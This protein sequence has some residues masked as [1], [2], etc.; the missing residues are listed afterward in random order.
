MLIYIAVGT[1]DD[2]ILII[3]GVIA[4]VVVHRWKMSLIPSTFP[5]KVDNYLSNLSSV[6]PML[7]RFSLTIAS[8]T[9]FVMCSFTPA[10]TL[11]IVPCNCP[12]LTH[13]LKSI[14]LLSPSPPDMVSEK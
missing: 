5:V 3:V 14:G 4:V 8:V 1:I 6:C 13:S 2:R 10:M 12:W 11:V 7:P 9:D